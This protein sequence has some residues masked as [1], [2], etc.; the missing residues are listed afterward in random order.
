MKLIRKIKDAFSVRLKHW[1]CGKMSLPKLVIE[2]RKIDLIDVIAI[3]SLN[4]VQGLSNA[5][6]EILIIRQMLPEIRKYV[7]FIDVEM[8][9]GAK[10][11]Q[12]ILE[13][14]KVT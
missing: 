13:V 11:K 4:D 3:V 8:H 5:D 7:S 12:G 6:I 1:L 2:H 10:Y 9:D 14:V